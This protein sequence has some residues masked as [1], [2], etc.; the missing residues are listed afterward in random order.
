MT[1]VSNTPSR[2]SRATA[3]EL[4]TLA[5]LE[6]MAAGRILAT[7]LEPFAG[8]GKPYYRRTKSGDRA[9]NFYVVVDV[10]GCFI[11]AHIGRN[12]ASVA[13]ASSDYPKGAQVALK[14]WFEANDLPSDLGEELALTRDDFARLVSLS[15][16]S[17]DH[18]IIGARSF[19]ASPVPTAL[20]S[21]D[22]AI[23]IQLDDVA[24]QTVC[25]D[26]WDRVTGDSSC[27]EIEAANTQHALRTAIKALASANMRRRVQATRTLRMCCLNALEELEYLEVTRARNDM[28]ESLEQSLK[29]IDKANDEI[30]P[31]QEPGSRKEYQGTIKALINAYTGTDDLVAAAIARESDTDSVDA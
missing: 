26:I 12:M 23:T 27:E 17:T 30:N 13:A 7:S 9:T 25:K 14:P 16:A 22:P 1:T 11:S 8:L 3:K 18:Y 31:D 21:T 5:G 28:R 4:E 10:D 2:D 24:F 19:V 15:V 20:P 29:T 6:L